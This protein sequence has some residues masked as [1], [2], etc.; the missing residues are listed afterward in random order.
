M[1]E[2]RTARWSASWSSG[3]AGGGLGRVTLLRACDAA[4]PRVGTQCPAGATRSPRT[5]LGLRLR[6]LP[7]GGTQGWLP[8][9]PGGFTLVRARG[10]ARMGP[11]CDG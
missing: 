4:I 5:T 10:T 1:S 11:R 7:L 8:W 3:L 9:L 6:R 2:Q